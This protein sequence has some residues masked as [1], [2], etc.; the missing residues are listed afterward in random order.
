MG[1]EITFGRDG[2][3]SFPKTHFL[4]LARKSHFIFIT[5]WKKLISTLEII[6]FHD[7]KHSSP[8]SHF[9]TKFIFIIVMEMTFACENSFSSPRWKWKLVYGIHFHHRNDFSAIVNGHSVSE[10][11]F[12]SR[13]VIFI[14]PKLISKQPETHFQSAG[15]HF[16]HRNG[17]DFR[18]RKSFSFP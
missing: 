17:N 6:H 18:W 4:E 13:K 9:L 14:G 5:R 16:H 10:T 15:I 3:K 1:M 11:H 8:K 7:G 2:K 12:H